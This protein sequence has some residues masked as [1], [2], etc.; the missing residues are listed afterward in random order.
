MTLDLTLRMRPPD[1][2]A[3]HVCMYFSESTLCICIYKCKFLYAYC[4]SL[5]GVIVTL[6]QKWDVDA[7]HVRFVGQIS[8]HSGLSHKSKMICREGLVAP[9]RNAYDA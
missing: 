8:F 9:L 1:S 3:N 7:G 2:S 6:V 5:F 4:G